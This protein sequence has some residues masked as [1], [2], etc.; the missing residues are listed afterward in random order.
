VNNAGR[1]EL[2][3]RGEGDGVGPSGHPFSIRSLP[4]TIILLCPSGLPVRAEQRGAG[5]GQGD[6]PD[7]GD[8]APVQYLAKDQ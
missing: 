8:G 3:G 1:A 4:V 5:G 6:E 2:S 7:G